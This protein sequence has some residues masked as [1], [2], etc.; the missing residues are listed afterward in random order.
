MLQPSRTKKGMLVRWGLSLALVIAG[1]GGGEDT[2]TPIAQPPQNVALPQNLSMKG[3]R[4]FP[5]EPFLHIDPTLRE[6]GDVLLSFGDFQDTNAAPFT[7]VIGGFRATGT[8]TKLNIYTLSVQ[9][10]T[11][12]AASSTQGALGPQVGDQLLITINLSTTP[13]Q[14]QEVSVLVDANG[15]RDFTRF[16]LIGSPISVSR[17]CDTKTGESDPVNLGTLAPAGPEASGGCTTVNGSINFQEKDSH[18][19]LFADTFLLGVQPADQII[20]FILT[21]PTV[22]DV[23]DRATDFDMIIRRTDDPSITNNTNVL[24][25][26]VSRRVGQEAC[27]IVLQRTDFAAGSPLPLEITVQARFLGS[28]D[29]T[30]FLAPAGTGNYTLEIVSTVSPEV[31]NRKTIC[32][33]TGPS[34][35][36]EQ[37][38]NGSNGKSVV[39]LA[40][41]GFDLDSDPLLFQGV[42][43]LQANGCIPIRGGY[44]G[45]NFIET[46]VVGG[47]IQ[48][49]AAEADGFD[50]YEFFVEDTVSTV[51]FFLQPTTNL[52]NNTLSLNIDDPTTT[53]IT[54]LAQCQTTSLLPPPAW[55]TR[56]VYRLGTFKPYPSR[57][58]LSCFCL[59]H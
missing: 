56:Y 13:S 45:A 36:L 58:G 32:P 38:T 35:I 52:T 57:G 40:H 50:K 37:D 42:G 53:P 21:F 10:S 8:A 49:Q 3:F 11:F 34:T 41:T 16:T 44:I 15:V 48:N 17:T 6:Q 26:C 28:E 31:G 30:P 39:N 23:D 22:N 18:G 33:D 19:R 46:T 55:Y 9:E 20:Q 25:S 54:H 14:A 5:G 24:Q 51:A 43:T 59:S 1:C 29:S 2:S 47:T 4:F 7:L 27:S 12:P